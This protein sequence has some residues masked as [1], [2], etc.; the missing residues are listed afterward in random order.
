MAI[1]IDWQV[2][3]HGIEH[4][5]YFQGCGVSFTKYDF[6]VTGIGMTASEAREDCYEQ[7]AQMGFAIPEELEDDALAETG[8]YSVPEHV[9]SEDNNE[10]YVHISIRVRTNPGANSHLTKEASHD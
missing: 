5:Q 3:N 10:C 2:I 9:A 8:N 7:L 6:C 4:S 1:L